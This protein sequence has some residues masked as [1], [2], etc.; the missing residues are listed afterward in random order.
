MYGCDANV[1]GCQ[2]PLHSFTHRGQNHTALVQQLMTIFAK[3]DQTSGM[4]A[5]S[6][7]NLTAAQAQELQQRQAEIHEL[8]LAR[9]VP[10]LKVEI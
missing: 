8:F 5:L 1:A 4:D 7:Q 10:T 6:L 9:G 3:P 2:R